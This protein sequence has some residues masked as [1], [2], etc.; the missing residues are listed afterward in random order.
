MPDTLEQLDLLLVTA[1]TPRIVH[2]DGIYFQGLLY[3][4][5]TPGRLRPRNRGSG[6]NRR[7]SGGYMA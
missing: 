4:H 3:L 6:S 7:K 5:P 2:R 1:A